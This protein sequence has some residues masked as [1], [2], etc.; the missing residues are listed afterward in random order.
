MADTEV[1]GCLTTDQ[2]LQDTAEIIQS[3]R[4]NLS[5]FSSPVI[6]AG[7]G[8]SGGIITTNQIIF[9]MFIRKNKQNNLIKPTL[10]E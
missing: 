1:R 10:V 6:I 2:A 5:A 7:S 9:F 3:F 4:A 8:Y